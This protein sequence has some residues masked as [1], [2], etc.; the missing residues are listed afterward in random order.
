MRQ[1]NYDEARI[2]AQA[3]EDGLQEVRQD[4]A[5]FVTEEVQRA[6]LSPEEARDLIR[7]VVRE[8]LDRRPKRPWG[9][10]WPGLI[11]GFLA[12]LAAATATLVL[13]GAIQ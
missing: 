7:S 1:E 8:E 10:W 4:V 2:L 5:S 13:S 12:G 11:G 6:G 9:S 3:L